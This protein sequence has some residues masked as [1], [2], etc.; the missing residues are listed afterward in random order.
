VIDPLSRLCTGC[1]R[2]LAEI[3]GWRDYSDAERR[4]I[5][6][7]LPERRA[8]ADAPARVAGAGH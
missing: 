7:R 5:M 2:T 8:L 6:N 3:G 4:A 1:G